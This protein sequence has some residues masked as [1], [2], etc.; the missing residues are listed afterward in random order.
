MEADADR[1]DLVLVVTACT[2]I[3]WIVASRFVPVLA[4]RLANGPLDLVLDT[5]GLV[6]SSA[7]AVLAWQ[8]YGE[9]RESHLLFQAA[10]FL[11]IAIPNLAHVLATTTGLEVQSGLSALDPDGAPALVLLV[12]PVLGAALLVAGAIPATRRR[13]AEHP[14]LLLLGPVALVVALEMVAQVFEWLEPISEVEEVAVN[15]SNGTLPAMT[16]LGTA[17]LLVG[18]GLFLLGTRMGRRRWRDGRRIDDAFLALGLLIAAYSELAGVAE[19]SNYVGE[20]TIGGILR[21]AFYLVLLVGLAAATRAIVRGLR[22]ADEGRVR[23]RAVEAERGRLEER[24][25]LAR[26]LQNGLAQSLWLAKLKAGRLGTVGDLGPEGMLLWHELDGALD[27]GLTEARQAVMTLRQDAEAWETA[28]PELLRDAIADLSDRYG[29]SIGLHV[30]PD[31]PRLGHRAESELLSIVDEAIVNARKHAAATTVAVRVEHRETVVV[32]SV[33]DDGQGFDPR[34][35][36]SEGHGLAV[37]RERAALMGAG[38]T[39]ES[40]PSRGTL[41]TIVVPVPAA[42]ADAATV[43][44]SPGL[45]GP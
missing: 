20:V 4:I 19:P 21:L 38:I 39:I 43:D 36:G 35:A 42:D 9:L 16:P 6:A 31:V 32:V 23:L 13:G 37:M 10:A 45:R 5:I 12:A 3:A 26:D 8:R 11:V 28:F 40:Q 30:D 29:M 24:A 22:S 2:L 1:L 27:V 34:S 41:V 18:V 25:Q 15:A 17:V 14:W 7:V 44:P 33:R